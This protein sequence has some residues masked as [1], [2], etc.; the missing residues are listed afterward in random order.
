MNKSKASSKRAGDHADERFESNK[1]SKSQS[2][3]SEQKSPKNPDEKDLEKVTGHDATVWNH[4]MKHKHLSF[5]YCRFKDAKTGAVCNASY[6]HD[7]VCIFF[8]AFCFTELFFSVDRK[9]A[10]PSGKRARHRI[11]QRETDNE[12]QAI[13][14]ELWRTGRSVGQPEQRRRALQAHSLAC[15]LVSSVHHDRRP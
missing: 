3:N 9:F 8:S 14:I 7:G 13:E 2:G 15:E 12:H 5:V 10:S 6:K 1:K 4:F 11:G